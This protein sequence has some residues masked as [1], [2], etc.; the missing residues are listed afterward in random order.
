M[1][2]KSGR[3][4]YAHMEIFGI[5]PELDMVTC[6]Y[7]HDIERDGENPLTPDE[8]RE[9]AEEMISRWR[10]WAKPETEPATCCCGQWGDWTRYHSQY[11]CGP[12]CA[13]KATVA[14]DVIDDCHHMAERCVLRNGTVLASRGSNLLSKAQ[15]ADE[16]EKLADCI[17]EPSTPR[18]IAES[19][20]ASALRD[21]ARHLRIEA[22]KES[23]E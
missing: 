6:G 17:Y 9:L 5:T 8:R 13:C 15:L 20:V 12:I 14:G 23:G 1:K 21:R 19:E 22:K 16:F 2:F 3:E 10:K 11:R 18:G 7:D 4:I